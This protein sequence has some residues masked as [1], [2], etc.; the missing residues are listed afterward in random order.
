VGL[1]FQKVKPSGFDSNVLGHKNFKH[2]IFSKENYSLG[3]LNSY[4]LKIK[5]KNMHVLYV[6][7]SLC[8]VTPV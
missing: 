2:S 6:M 8:K 1:F 4:H 7:Q 3:S 5:Y